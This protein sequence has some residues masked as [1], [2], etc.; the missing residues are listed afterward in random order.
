MASRHL[1]HDR[2]RHRVRERALQVARHLAAPLGG[3][4]RVL[5]L[6]AA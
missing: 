3:R 4:V 5:G 1:H 6:R 2:L